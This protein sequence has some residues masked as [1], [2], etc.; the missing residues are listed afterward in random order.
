MEGYLTENNLSKWFLDGHDG[1]LNSRLPGGGKVSYADVLKDTDRYLNKHIHPEVEKLVALTEKDIFLTDHGPDHIKMV[2]RRAQYL[3]PREQWASNGNEM[4]AGLLEPYEVFLLL[5]AIHF[6]DVGNMY[7]RE[8]HEKRITD[9]MK[10]TPTL[11]ELDRFEQGLIAKIAA[12]HGGTIHNDRNTIVYIPAKEKAGDVVFRPR[13]IAA[14]LRL[15]DELADERSRASHFAHR[16][17]DLL[18]RGCLIYHRY[19][20]ALASVHVD[21]KNQQLELKFQLSQSDADPKYQLGDKEVYLLDYIYQRTLK[22]YREMIY[23]SQFTRDLGCQFHQVLVEVDTLCDAMD[24]EPIGKIS[25]SIGEI[26]YPGDQHGS[27]NLLAP[28]FSKAPCGE[29]LAE[30]LRSKCG[31]PENCSV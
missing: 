21:P 17:P 25:F 15:A 16:K 27:L 5:M 8:G 29:A 2:M 12:C 28:E 23:C 10:E 6:H 7:G 30:D 14:L 22:T 4:A 1:W 26:G 9:V 24:R 31:N 11:C 13:L 19:A 3:V 20:S 18:P